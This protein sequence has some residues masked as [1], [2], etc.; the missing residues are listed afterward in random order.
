L[1]RTDQFELGGNFGGNLS[2]AVEVHARGENGRD[3]LQSQTTMGE[4]DMPLGKDD[5]VFLELLTIKKLIIAALLFGSCGLALPGDLSL[6]PETP[7]FVDPGAGVGLGHGA[8]FLYNDLVGTQYT[9]NP[10]LSNGNIVP[11]NISA[12]STSFA[13]T[14]AL[15]RFVGDG[16]YVKGSY[17]YF[18]QFS[19]SG[20]ADFPPPGSPSV[21]ANFQQIEISTAHGAFLAGGFVCDLTHQLYLDFSGEVGA[22]FIRSGGVHDANLF[23]QNFPPA[24]NT[25]LAGGGGLG[26][27]YRL[28][29]KLTL[30]LG[31]DYDYLGPAA[32]G[33]T[34]HCIPGTPGAHAAEHVSSQVSVISLLGGVRFLIP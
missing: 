23:P 31:A 34:C 4:N 30:T 11:S 26:F 24:W 19:A 12:N 29:P 33:I 21:N 9:T 14:F 32:S 1:L 8:S 6:P 18:G 28:T 10:V 2:A 27:G 5:I 13:G 25:N 7:W 3:L 16:F 20:Y 22:A 17:R 15:G